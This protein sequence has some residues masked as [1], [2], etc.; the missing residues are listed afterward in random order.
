MSLDSTDSRSGRFG[1][2]RSSQTEASLPIGAYGLGAVVVAVDFILIF[3]AVI[4]AAFIY[5]LA[6]GNANAGAL[7]YAAVGT[8][9]FA[10]F[11]VL[12]FAMGAYRVEALADRRGQVQRVACAWAVATLSGIA[13]LAAAG[14]S[15]SLPAIGT[16]VATT[17][18]ALLGW[19]LSLAAWAHYA[20][21]AGRLPDR[22]VL[23]V[24]DRSQ[25]THANPLGGLLGE[26]YVATGTLTYDKSMSDAALHKMSEEVARKGIEAGATSVALIADWNDITLM[27]RVADALRVVPLSVDLLPDRRIAQVMQRGTGTL[28]G[29]VTASIQRAPMSRAAYGAKRAFDLLFAGAALLALAPLFMFVALLIKLDSR[30]PVFFRQVRAGFGGRLFHIY[31]FRTMVSGPQDAEFR[32]A[33]RQ[34]D[35]VTRVGRWLRKTSIDELPQLLNVLNGT[36]SIVGPRPHPIALNDGFRPLVG[37][38]SLRHHVKPGLTG[39]AQVHGWRGETRTLQQMQKRVEHDLYYIENWSFGLDLWIVLLSARVIFH[40]RA[41]Y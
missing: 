3:S 27:E 29:T 37:D 22:R 16:F 31:K 33:T 28:G 15:I 4:L 36:M 14:T 18:V 26:G 40:D 19:R 2:V 38:Y 1:A 12:C 24:A 23:V 5:N 9:F 11:T 20:L 8:V 34:D 7:R 41:A 39:W 35:R 13:L 10:N 6:T 21:R 30:G 17:C 32:Q 25:I